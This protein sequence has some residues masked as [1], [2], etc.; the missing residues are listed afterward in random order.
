MKK[1]FE[2]IVHGTEYSA[3]DK[4]TWTLTVWFDPD[5]ERVFTMDELDDTDTIID[6]VTEE[7]AMD[8]AL[9]YFSCGYEIV[10]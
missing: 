6:D 8:A 1:L 7:K 10:A 2:V 5:M 3:Y 9:E 4:E